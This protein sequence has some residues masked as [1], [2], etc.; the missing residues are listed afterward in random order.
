M[1]SLI[2]GTVLQRLTII[3]GETPVFLSAKIRLSGQAI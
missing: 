1:I 3:K 2:N